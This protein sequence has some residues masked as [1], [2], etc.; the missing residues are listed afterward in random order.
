MSSR[1]PH[2]ASSPAPPRSHR[3]HRAR[4]TPSWLLEQ[5][6]LD[7]I[8]RRRTLMILTV[9]S[10]AQPVSDAIT[11]AKISRGAYYQFETRALQAMVSA[12]TPGADT[13][14]STHSPGG[15]I[16]AL[17]AKVKRLEQD[18]R[19]TERL[20]FLTRQV[21]KPGTLKTSSGRPGKPTTRPSSSTRAGNGSSRR[22]RTSPSSAPTSPSHP[23][24]TPTPTGAAAPSS[25]TGS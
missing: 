13:T 15:R 8:A 11:E 21:V 24:S 4:P 10:G 22:S 16:A 17:E 2:R 14:S 9:L 25:G 3:K 5:T 7:E 23:G 12:L 1:K 6:D 20:L 18:K 19:R